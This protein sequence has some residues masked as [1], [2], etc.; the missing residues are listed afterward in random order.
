[1]WPT[2]DF[3]HSHPDYCP[4]CEVEFNKHVDLRLLTILVDRFIDENFDDETKALAET[5]EVID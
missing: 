5:V 2:N 1:M 4:K 3:K